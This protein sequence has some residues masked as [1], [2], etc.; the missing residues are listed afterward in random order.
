MDRPPKQ[1]FRQQAIDAQREKLL[2]EV[3]L[4]RPVPLWV[5]TAMA[6]SFAVALVAFTIWG[7]Y[8]RRERVDGF[9]ALDAGAARILAPE[10]G[11]VANCWPMK[12]TRSKPDNL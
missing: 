8:A 5:F 4:A 6:L 7:E 10:P 3:S 12:A 11:T 2:G 1:L 9:L